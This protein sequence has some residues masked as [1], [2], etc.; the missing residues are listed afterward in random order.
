MFRN[1]ILLFLLSFAF[2]DVYALSDEEIRERFQ[3][4]AEPSCQKSKL[5]EPR[6]PDTEFYSERYYL[7]VDGGK[8]CQILDVWVE[9]LT[10]LGNE[11]RRYLQSVLYRRK[12]GVW[13]KEYGL[14]D[15]PKLRLLDRQTGKVYFY[16]KLE[17][18]PF[19][20]EDIVYFDG[21]WKKQE[22]G[23]SFIDS[24][25]SVGGCSENNGDACIQETS[26]V[27]RAVE[28]FKSK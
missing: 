27:R 28:L 15:M 25:R 2:V 11:N 5:H 8:E 20:R 17:E 10:K 4:V 14:Q 9:P 24:I 16:I 26:M 22:K 3:L 7:A 6:K 1:S 13:V 21:P 18:L 12:G 19:N 23:V